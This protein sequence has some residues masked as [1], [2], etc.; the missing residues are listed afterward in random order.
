VEDPTAEG[1]LAALEAIL[2]LGDL[3]AQGLERDRRRARRLL[4][5]RERRVHGGGTRRRRG[6]GRELKTA[7]TT[8]KAGEDR[9]EKGREGRREVVEGER[10]AAEA[11]SAQTGEP[12]VRKGM[13]LGLAGDP[14]RAPPSL[15]A[16]DPGGER[17]GRRR[18]S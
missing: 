1:V 17:P 14:E 7:R 6:K 16:A 18:F 13:T 15:K 5:R 11:R 4:D 3:L 2:E 12:S 9:R 8:R 10:A